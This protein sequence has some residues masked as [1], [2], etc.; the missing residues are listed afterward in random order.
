MAGERR[1]SL[2]TENE[3]LPMTATIAQFSKISG[4]G[5]TSIYE[6]INSGEL[7]TV[8][9]CGR[10]LILVESYRN[11]LRVG[12]KVISARIRSHQAAE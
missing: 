5:K 2:R 4:L 6:L 12:Q 11:L 7:G 10:R 1:P 8:V 9:I 3:P